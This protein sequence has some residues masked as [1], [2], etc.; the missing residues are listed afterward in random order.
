MMLSKALNRSTTAAMLAAKR[1]TQVAFIM[2]QTRAF[3]PVTKY[4][5]DDEDWEPNQYQV[6]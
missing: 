2:P 6:S 5:F 1:A 3:A 4:K